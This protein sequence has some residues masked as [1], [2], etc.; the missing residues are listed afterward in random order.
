M[1]PRL[2][3]Q[4]VFT[5]L[6]ISAPL[7]AL[8]ATATFAPQADT[9]VSGGNERDLNFGERPSLLV[10]RTP[11]QRL[12]IRFN[13]AEIAAAVG[14]NLVIDARL[15]LFVLSSANWGNQEGPISVYAVTTSWTEDGATFNCPDDADLTN[16]LP[17]CPMV[18]NGG[19]FAE[20]ASGTT[21]HGNTTREWVQFDVTADVR[22]FLDDTANRGW[23]LRKPDEGRSGVVEYVSREGVEDRRPRL[24]VE[25]GP[26]TPTPTPSITATPTA[27][28]SPPP[29]SSGG[30]SCAIGTPAAVF[31]P[32]VFLMGTGIWL[33][34][35]TRPPR[36]ADCDGRRRW[37]PGLPAV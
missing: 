11:R 28:E 2:T 10:R 13:E 24:V 3:W 7:E 6:L 9:Y 35:S 22:A 34:L 4:R 1:V 29:A 14:G 20:D 23:L 27:T 30:S 32:W 16:P 37:R 12:L 25:F 18:W 15:E 33:G 17:N 19:T 36:R 26:A 5:L 21:L 8:A 31:T